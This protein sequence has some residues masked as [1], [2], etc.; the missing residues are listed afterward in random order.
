[1]GAMERDRVQWREIEEPD[2]NKAE[3]M[4]LVHR[5]RIEVGRMTLMHME[6]KMMP[7]IS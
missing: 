2:Q 6:R 1:M 4:F 7:K 3:W 5:G